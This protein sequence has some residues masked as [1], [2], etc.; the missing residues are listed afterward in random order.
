MPALF[1]PFAADGCQLRCARNENLPGKPPSL[2]MVWVES[3]EAV[4]RQVRLRPSGWLRFLM[5]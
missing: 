3:L 1:I 2:K 5:V 4:W